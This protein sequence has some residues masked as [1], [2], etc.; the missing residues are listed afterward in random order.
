MLD[1]EFKNREILQ[2]KKENQRLLVDAVD[3]LNAIYKY[4][5]VKKRQEMFGRIKEAVDEF[6]L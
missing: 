1:E 6:G 2:F 5:P 3:F 4:L